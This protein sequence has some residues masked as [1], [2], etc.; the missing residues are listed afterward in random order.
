MFGMQPQPPKVSEEE[1]AMNRKK[2]V[3]NFTNFVT[4]VA[5]IRLVPFAIEY[6]QKLF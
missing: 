4:L 1:K 2:T 5:A 3:S 6:A